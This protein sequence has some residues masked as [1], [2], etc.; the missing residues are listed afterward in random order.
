M[1]YS[2]KSLLSLSTDLKQMGQSI[3]P[4]GFSFLNHSVS[5]SPEVLDADKRREYGRFHVEWFSAVAVLSPVPRGTPR[6]LAVSGNV[7]SDPRIASP[8]SHTGALPSVIGRFYTPAT[9]GADK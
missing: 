4:Y 6:L 7:F 1:G 8:L 5:F 3:L 9:F 2:L